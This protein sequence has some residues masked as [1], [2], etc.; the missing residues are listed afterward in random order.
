MGKE[1]FK[2]QGLVGRDGKRWKV[3]AKIKENTT[4]RR[5]K[6]WETNLFPESF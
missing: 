2:T 5:D 6:S 3:E 1:F 4:R